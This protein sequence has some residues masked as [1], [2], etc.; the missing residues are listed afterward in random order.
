MHRFFLK[1]EQITNNQVFFHPGEINQIKNVLRLSSGDCVLVLDNKGNSYKV[2]ISKYSN[3]AL[4]GNIIENQ[5]QKPDPQFSVSLG[6]AF[7]KGPNM[8]FIIQKATELGVESIILFESERSIIRY[9]KIKEKNRVA[10][11][12]KI[13]KEAAEQSQRLTIPKVSCC[14]SINDFFLSNNQADLK[15]IFWEDETKK[16]LRDCLKNDI[17]KTRLS[18]LVGPEGGFSKNEIDIAV[19]FGFIPVGLGPRILKTATAVMSILSIV[20]YMKGELG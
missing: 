8:D 1:P 15:L 7:T 19:K 2:E 18:F 11:W 20:Q 17:D 14:R 12:E 13:A 4:T 5:Y 3:K 9:E 10:R 16:K 6:Q